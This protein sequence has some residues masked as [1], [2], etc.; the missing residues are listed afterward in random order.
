MPLALASLFRYRYLPA[1]VTVNNRNYFSRKYRYFPAVLLSSSPPSSLSSSL[2][3]SKFFLLNK[4]SSLV[5]SAAP[6]SSYTILRNQKLFANSYL[7]SRTL[8]SKSSST[9]KTTSKTNNINKSSAM[10]RL[11]DYPPFKELREEA[12]KE[13][14]AKG[15]TK[16]AELY[17]RCIGTSRTGRIFY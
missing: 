11:S 9:N 5:L 8:S 7:N 10:S 2:L 3:T 1:I 16:A 14:A 15:Y 13:I 6:F 12:K 4:P 17:S